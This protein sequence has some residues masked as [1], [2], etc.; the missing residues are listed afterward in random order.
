MPDSPAFE[1]L[2]GEIK[3]RLDTY[4]AMGE[5]ER[6]AL[7]NTTEDHE[8]RLVKLETQV[9]SARTLGG[10]LRWAATGLAA[11][12]GGLITHYWSILK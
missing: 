9:A 7:R 5:A 8:T 4:I 2:L 11:A 12:L 1:R 10:L 6:A 3:G